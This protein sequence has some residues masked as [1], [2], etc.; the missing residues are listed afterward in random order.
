MLLLALAFADPPEGVD[1]DDLDRWEGLANAALDGPVG[2]WEFEG[3]LQVHFALHTRAA[4]WRRAE[5]VPFSSAGTWSGRLSDGEWTRFEYAL[6]NGEG[7]ANE[8]P[9]YPVIGKIDPGNVKALNVPEAP[10]DE[11]K[12]KGI[13]FSVGGK[14]EKGDEADDGEDAEPA[15]SSGTSTGS[16][17]SL[18]RNALDGWHTS[19]AFSNA[20]WNEGRREI[21]LVQDVPTTDSPNAPLISTTTL[22]P[23][24]AAFPARL[25]TVFPRKMV[26]GDWPLKV[27]V[28]DAQF[29][30]VQQQ[31][32]G[33]VL[34]SA[35][36]MS[37]AGSALGF[38]VSYEQRLDYRTARRCAP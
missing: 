7:E 28:Y 17:V 6:V 22:F 27:H 18:L 4:L 13:S 31:V 30:L 12:G 25:S 20:V 36:N 1:P 3:E 8:V 26:M 16:A 5:E 34:P 9:I 21:K 23:E 37:A 11:E 2:C 10:E 15:E 35:E 32:S 19:T 29:H 14:G 24:G 38:T 33:Q